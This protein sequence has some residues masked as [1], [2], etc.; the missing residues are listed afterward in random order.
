MMLRLVEIDEQCL[1]WASTEQ[2]GDRE[3]VLKAVSR[4]GQV[5]GSAS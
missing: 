1:S 5:L 3:I 4:Q 2:K